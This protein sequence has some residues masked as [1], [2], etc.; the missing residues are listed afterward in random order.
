MVDDPAR[1]IV[2]QR[3]CLSGFGLHV[4]GYVRIGVSASLM[5]VLPDSVPGPSLLP[6][7]RQD[8]GRHAVRLRRRPGP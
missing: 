2:D 5:P 3:R 4:V 7:R 6:E 1:R 8:L